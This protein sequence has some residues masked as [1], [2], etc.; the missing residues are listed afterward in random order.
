MQI[1]DT[2]QAMCVHL[3][4]VSMAECCHCWWSLMCKRQNC[5]ILLL[6]GRSNWPNVASKMNTNVAQSRPNVNFEIGITHSSAYS[7]FVVVVILCRWN[8]QTM[9]VVVTAATYSDVLWLTDRQW[10]RI[11]ASCQS[12]QPRQSS[13]VPQQQHRHRRLQRCKSRTLYLFS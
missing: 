13:W 1:S 5:K 3:P 7:V 10:N 12:R 8:V 9:L 4:V 11:S 2:I 6:E